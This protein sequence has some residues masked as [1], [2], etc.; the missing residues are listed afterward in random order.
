MN[1]CIKAY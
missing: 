1:W